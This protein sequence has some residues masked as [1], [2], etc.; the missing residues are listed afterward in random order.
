[1]SLD[2][3]CPCTRV[4]AGALRHRPFAEQ[5]GEDR[6]RLVVARAEHPHSHFDQEGR[7]VADPCQ[8]CLLRFRLRR[9]LRDADHAVVNPN[10]EAGAYSPPWDAWRLS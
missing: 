7:R 2:P 8:H 10:D 1:M 6:L 9:S 4:D 3:L 5:L